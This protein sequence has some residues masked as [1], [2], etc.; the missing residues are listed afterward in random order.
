[1]ATPVRD[2]RKYQDVLDILTEVLRYTPGDDEADLALDARR[3]VF[4]TSLLS[5][6]GDTLFLWTQNVKCTTPAAEANFAAISRTKLDINGAIATLITDIDADF[7]NVTNEMTAILDHIVLNEN[8]E[9]E[10]RSVI[11]PIAPRRLE[12]TDHAAN[13]KVNQYLVEA[14]SV[15]ARM[16]LCINRVDYEM[17]KIVHGDGTHIH[18]PVEHPGVAHLEALLKDKI[19]I[20]LS[21][22]HAPTVARKRKEPEDPTMEEEDTSTTPQTRRAL[23][24]TKMEK[25]RD[26]KVRDM[27]IKIKDRQT[28]L[29]KWTNLD[30]D[31]I[32]YRSLGWAKYAIENRNRFFPQEYRLK[33]TESAWEK[34]FGVECK[35]NAEQ[36]EQVQVY[37]LRYKGHEEG[38]DLSLK[39]DGRKE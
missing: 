9:N 28:Q 21:N 6:L 10:L 33:V 12:I 30:D 36:L 23:I 13:E 18:I 3:T 4:M 15:P 35:L 17:W 25:A 32:K 8:L 29:K 16:T 27:V 7:N 26:D 34:L 1:M 39:Q 37:Y 5:N 20:T 22:C 38:Y 2:P 31:T 24:Q 19:K 11:P 14:T